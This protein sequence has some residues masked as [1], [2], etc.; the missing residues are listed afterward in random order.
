MDNVAAAT[1]TINGTNANNAINYT[2][3][4]GGGIFVGNTGLVTVDG[5]ESYEF[6]N[7]TNLQLNGNAGDDVINLNNPTTPAGLTGT[8]TVNGG[9]PTASD[10]LIV[11]GTLGR[12][13]S[14]TTP[15]GSAQ[16]R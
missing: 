8:I 1:L 6:N 5:F 2:Q 14:V 4:P 9:D 13:Q 10:K 15:T 16:G 12:I 3:G 7:K 11:N